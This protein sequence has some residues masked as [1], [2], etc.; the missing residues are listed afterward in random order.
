[1]ATPRITA[2]STIATGNWC[3][4]PT[5]ALTPSNRLFCFFT[6]STGDGVAGGKITYM[7]SDNFGGSWSARSY[8]T[9]APVAN[10]YKSEGS[11]VATTTGRIIKSYVY[12]DTLDN[13]QTAMYYI[14]S[15]NAGTSWSAETLLPANFTLT[16]Y[17][18][19]QGVQHTNGAIVL[20]VYG[21]DTADTN[22][23]TKSRNGVFRSTDNGATW[24]FIRIS[25]AGTGLTEASILQ[26]PNGN[27]RAYIRQEGVSSGVNL[28]TSDSTNA[29]LTW[30]APTA[31]T[32]F[33]AYP[34]GPCPVLIAGTQTMVMFYRQPTTGYAA[35]RI[36]Y[37]TGSTWTSE[38]LHDSI[39]MNNGAMINT[40]FDV[41]IGCYGLQSSGTTSNLQGFRVDAETITEYTLPGTNEQVYDMCQGPDGNVWYTDYT[42]SKIGRITPAGAIAKYATTTAASH[43][44]GICAGPDGNIWF[45]EYGVGKVGTCNVSGTMLG[46]YLS[47]FGSGAQPYGICSDG[48]TLWVTEAGANKI[49]KVTTGGMY[50]EFSTGLFAN[51]QC[52][53]IRKASD[54]NMW[55]AENN[56]NKIG[57]ITPS[58]T[59][60]EFG[61]LATGSAPWY[62]CIGPDGNIWF[63]EANGHIGVMNLSGTL[64]HEYAIPFGA[65]A[66]ALG[67]AVGADGA[68]WFAESPA[69]SITIGRC[70]TTGVMTEYVIPTANGRPWAMTSGADGNIWFSE[71]TANAIGVFTMN[72]LS[73]P[74]FTLATQF[75][76]AV[77]RT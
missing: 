4:Y 61:G 20:P 46:E 55:F 47:P 19:G 52:Y 16:R 32:A 10:W 40:D 9:A 21:L 28:S 44:V 42:N 60:T 53:M 45:T 75:S 66:N 15:D 51:C 63:P 8:P 59:I 65:T 74:T 5:L 2:V 17:S 72:I 27:L 37:D 38:T 50:T 70:T 14:T 58:G 29:G 35:Y 25:T 22:D 7:T 12:A 34:G 11:T 77:Y 67:I 48:T 33:L 39:V 23:F 26:L 41:A 3:A 43:P 36:S 24:T 30:S 49:A 68:V 69:N 71:V 62:V 13:T 56:N 76:S 18:T 6:E 57:R 31:L 73:P 1:M 64:L 54:G